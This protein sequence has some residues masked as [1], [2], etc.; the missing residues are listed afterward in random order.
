MQDRKEQIESLVR[1]AQLGDTESFGELYELLVDDVYRYLYGKIREQD[2]EDLCADVFLKAWQYLPSY[3]N[4]EQSSFRTWLLRIAH[5]TLIDYYRRFHNLS[6]IEEV[7]D[8]PSDD[9]MSSP[10]FLTNQE[11]NRNHLEKMLNSLKMEYRQVLVLRYLN[12][13]SNTEISEILGKSETAIR[14]LIHRALKQLKE[15]T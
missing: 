12:E 15:L 8:V 11:L 2:R 3:T 14:I 9:E 10:S 1:A 5:N 6:H 7:L 13:Y 4:Q